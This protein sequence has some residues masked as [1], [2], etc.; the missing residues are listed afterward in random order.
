M[1]HVNGIF[2]SGKIKE[3]RTGNKYLSLMH[4]DKDKDGNKSSSFYTMWLN[5]KCSKLVDN[6][7]KKQMKDSSVLLKIDGYLKVSKNGDFINLTIIPMKVERFT[8]T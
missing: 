6:N 5:E 7:T 2:S 3:T 8:I 4:T 1:L